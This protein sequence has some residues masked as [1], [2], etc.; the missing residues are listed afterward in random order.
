LRKIRNK[1]YLNKK[2]S[3]AWVFLER[4]NRINFVGELGV[5]GN[6]NGGIG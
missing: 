3:D 2:R 1:R 6:K 4:G 5:V